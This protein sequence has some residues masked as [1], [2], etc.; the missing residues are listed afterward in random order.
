MHRFFVSWLFPLAVTQAALLSINVSADEPRGA[1]APGCA[2]SA[3]PTTTRHIRKN[4]LSLSTAELDAL[5]QGVEVMKAR[6]AN[7]PTSWSFQ[8]NIHGENL[9]ANDPLWNQCQHGTRHFLTWHRLYIYQFEQILREA[10]GDPNLTLPY[11]DWST[12]RALPLAF[13]ENPTSNPL[14]ESSRNINNGASLPSSIVVNDLLLAKAQTSFAGFS[15]LFE[16]SPHGAVHVLIGGRMSSV[17]TAAN[18]PI[19]WLHHCNIDRVWD[20]WLNS[21]GGRQNPEDSA[22]LA[23]TFPLV[24]PDGSTIR[25]KVGEHILSSQLGY[26]YDDTPNPIPVAPGPDMAGAPPVQMTTTVVASSEPPGRPGEPAPGETAEHKLGFATSRITLNAAEEETEPLRAMAAAVEPEIGGSVYIDIKGIDFEAP[27]Q[28][29]YGVYLNLPEAEQLPD[30]ME[31]Y[32]VGTA[33]LFGDPKGEHHEHG[34]HAGEAAAP[35]LNYSFDAS[36]TISQLKSIGLWVEGPLVVTLRPISANA[37]PGEERDFIGRMEMAA[38][39]AD[40]TYQ[41]IEV[42]V[43]VPE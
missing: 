3:G 24:A 16:G 18:D 17:P 30:R 13:R 36:A 32:R 39:A 8:A 11:W 35:G 40:V 38:D 43:V 23:Q 42:R 12:A 15:N 25:M 6:S 22:F 31:L 20:A 2:I 29:V 19:F 1:I 14:F 21:G 33:N 27:P 41:A 4:I 5:R 28:F 10:S 7:D 37:P 26:V 34:H 9:P